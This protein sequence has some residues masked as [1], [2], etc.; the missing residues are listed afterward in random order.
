MRE[1]LDAMELLDPRLVMVISL[2]TL[3]I[4]IAQ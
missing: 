2:L 1:Q 4:K 3:I